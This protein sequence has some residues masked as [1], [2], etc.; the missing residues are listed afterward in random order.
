MLKK[1]TFST[2]YYYDTEWVLQEKGEKIQASRSKTE[3]WESRLAGVASAGGNKLW[4][5]LLRADNA[6]AAY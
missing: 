2:Y 4:Y 5:I 1:A 6:G 3:I